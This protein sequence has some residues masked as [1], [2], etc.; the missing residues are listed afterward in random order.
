MT[1][2]IK[3]LLVGFPCK[4]KQSRQANVKLT[5][6]SGSIQFTQRSLAGRPENQ[7]WGFSARRHGI[8][9]NPEYRRMTQEDEAK[10]YDQHPPYIQPPMFHVIA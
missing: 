10:V 2:R 3:K 8:L 5:T 7:R 9:F 4:S 1:K 6:G